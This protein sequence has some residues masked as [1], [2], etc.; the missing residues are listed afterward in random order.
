MTTD[1]GVSERL[2]SDADANNL[3]VSESG[4]KTVADIK[5]L[6]Q[7]GYRRFL[8]GESLMKETERELAVKN[9]VYTAEN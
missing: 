8:I 7:S 6:R 5:R 3:M 9:L 4:V 2:A 1:L